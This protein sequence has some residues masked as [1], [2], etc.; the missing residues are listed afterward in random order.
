MKK[1]RHCKSKLIISSQWLHDLLPKSRKQLDLFLILKGFPK[2]KLELMYKDCD[3]TIRHFI[4]FIKKTT[5]LP[6]NFMY[7]DATSD[8]SRCN[9][10]QQFLIKNKESD[11]D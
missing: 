9:F 2:E 11:F 6:H 10:N 1:N 4:K 8:T 7:I 3:S 5:K